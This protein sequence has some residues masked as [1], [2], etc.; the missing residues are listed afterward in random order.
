MS[1][2]HRQLIEDIWSAELIYRK[3]Q[4]WPLFDPTNGRPIED[5]KPTLQG[6]NVIN[7][8][9]S[10]MLRR[11]LPPR[12]FKN[13][14]LDMAHVRRR[15]DYTQNFSNLPTIKH[16]EASLNQK[17]M[18][19]LKNYEQGLFAA[20]CKYPENLFIGGGYLASFIQGVGL[21]LNIT[22][23]DIDVFVV[24]D[25]AEEAEA[26][27]S[28]FAACI[29]SSIPE[30]NR[31]WHVIF[32]SEVVTWKMRGMSCDIQLVRRLY[33]RRDEI[34]GGFDLWPSQVI[35]SAKHGIECTLMA[36]YSF[37]TGYFP[38]DVSKRSSSGAYRQ[39]KY[40]YEKQFTLLLP[41]IPKGVTGAACVDIAEGTLDRI[42]AY[43][44]LGPNVFATF[45]A[46]VLGP[47]HHR[48]NDYGD[49]IQDGECHEYWH[50]YWN[51]ILKG[52]AFSI[53]T[54]SYAAVSH[55]NLDEM[56]PTCF[57]NF[58][59]IGRGARK[60]NPAILRRF[61]RTHEDWEKWST[62]YYVMMNYEAAD[63][64]W[65]ENLKS[66]IAHVPELY[67]DLTKYWK[68]KNPGEQRF[69]Q[70]RPIAM[71]ALEYYGPTYTP[72]YA[73]IVPEVYF[74]LKLWIQREAINS[75]QVCPRDIINSIIKMYLK[76]REQDA[77][78]KLGFM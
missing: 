72:T 71:T 47:G 44:N 63:R 29:E 31:N 51:R 17:F 62:L 41:G 23:N 1:L 68:V 3:E 16:F 11:L 50:H 53:V 22:V 34:C 78:S 76:L 61:F 58:V 45:S 64:I 56:L 9:L 18:D 12:E 54:T 5:E 21:D 67:K 37:I 6:E 33:K 43:S 15:L 52:Q 75:Q 27:T 10:P 42:D 30:Y 19:Q 70:N 20:L 2:D 66:Y 57:A 65:T 40:V 59:T 38:V 35:W 4:R 69:G 55:L 14:T 32:H 49:D 48:R 28:D 8:S 39:A 60:H 73:G 74:V 36:L 26:I 13:L 46:V 77:L 7:A 25:T 24:A